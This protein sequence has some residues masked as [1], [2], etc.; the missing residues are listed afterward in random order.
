RKSVRLPAAE[1][2]LRPP[3]RS[4]LSGFPRQSRSSALRRTDSVQLTVWSDEAMASRA[5]S[6][7]LLSDLEYGVWTHHDHLRAVLP[8]VTKET[9]PA[10]ADIAAENAA[11]TAG[12]S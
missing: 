2:E 8:V 5:F 9:A 4:H 7:F 6:G 1:Q 3:L 11:L 10:E 12:R